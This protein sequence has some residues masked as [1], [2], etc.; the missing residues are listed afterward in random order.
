MSIA[1]DMHDLDGDV[2]LEIDHN[3][4]QWKRCAL[5]SSGR[6]HLDPNSASG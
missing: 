2:V 4:V 3:T 5:V 6:D 1:H